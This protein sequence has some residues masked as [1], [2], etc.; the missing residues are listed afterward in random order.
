MMTNPVSND[1]SVARLRRGRSAIV[2]A[3]AAALVAGGFAS[4]LTAQPTP[5]VP[6]AEPP[7]STFQGLEPPD[8]RWLVDQGGREYFVIELPRREQAYA[9]AAA[10]HTRVR[11]ANGLT[12]DVVSY[13]DDHFH[14]KVY[15]P[16]GEAGPVLGP[17]E[18]TAEELARIAASYRGEATPGPGID[19]RP[20]S[21]GLPQAGQWRHDFD[22]ADLNGDGHLDIVVGPS[23]KGARRLPTIFLG[24]GAGGWKPWAGASFPALP[25][26]YGTVKVA[27]LNGDG[28]PDL[29]VA[30]HLRG[31]VAMIGDGRGHFTAWSEGIDY[32]ASNQPQA[33]V[34]TTQSITIVDWNGDG[35]PDI[36][37]LG[38]GPSQ[39]AR[40]TAGTLGGF[41][42]G[43][44]GIVIYLNQGNG[45]WTKVAGRGSGSFGGTLA[46]A[47]FD[48]DGRM[49][50]V[51]GS[52]R[53]GFT[54]LLNLGQA[55]GTWKETPLPALRPDGIY[56]AVATADF[57]GDGR[58]DLAVSFLTREHGIF[59]TGI[60]VLLNRATGWE[61]RTLGA[62]ESPVTVY[63]L[64][65]GDLDGDGHVDV[66]GIDAD[67][68]LWIFRGDGKGGFTRESAPELKG[69]ERCQGYG[70]RLVD[71]D[72]DGAD[73]IVVSFAAERVDQGPYG[74]GRWCPS[75]GA[76]Q[77]WKVV[78]KR[79]G[80]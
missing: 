55:D 17:R 51:A 5:S 40:P 38:E 54:A 70:L 34:F 60:D 24:D 74:K 30:V 44:R 29:V 71:L 6:S 53:W 9:W 68:A 13:T 64:A 3:I 73:E 49:D 18:A 2:A 48:R 14:V 46:V 21:T 35:R 36:V 19:L 61:R 16:T 67:G 80:G 25:F 11:L 65:T 50:I 59:R 31:V 76:L 1:R 72:R 52:D 7:V 23:R 37:A 28:I 66:V 63:R 15:R 26:D 20:F 32:V 47:D 8:G 22:V 4:H 57:D 78:P 77:V 69:R 27:D 58:P 75:E 45:S 39:V 12:W 10:D 33:S 62:V 41:R 43:S 79:I 56:R 42:A